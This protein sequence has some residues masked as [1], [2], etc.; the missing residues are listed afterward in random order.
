MSTST[1]CLYISEKKALNL[2]IKLILKYLQAL[3]LL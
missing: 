3:K 1:V 2:K